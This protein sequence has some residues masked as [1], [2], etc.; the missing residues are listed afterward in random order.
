MIGPYPDALD[1]WGAMNASKILDDNEWWRLI[2]P[3]FLHGYVIIY[4]FAAEY[5]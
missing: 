5:E 4:Y 1:N 3:I 2:T